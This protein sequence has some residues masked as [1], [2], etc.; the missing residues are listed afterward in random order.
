M[1]W[2][3]ANL[4]GQLVY[5]RATE[6]GDLAAVGGKVEIRY[7]PMD[8]R[9]YDAMVANLKVEPGPL[10]PDET[11]AAAERPEKAAKT[12]G[13]KAPAKAKKA[14]NAPA[15]PR[16]I[17][18]GTTIAYTDGACTGNPGPAGLGVVIVK[19]EGRREL[20][21]YLGEATNNIAELVA[22]ERAIE[23]TAPDDVVVHT[24]SQ[25]AIGVLSKGWKAKANTDLNMRIRALL[26]A[27]SGQRS[28]DFVYVPGHAG[29][30]LNERADEL[31]RL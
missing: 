31:A 20:S 25:Y 30:P 28:V 22:I 7:K 24:D 12:N 3:R 27:R 10:L 9:R 6:T 16:E 17:K 15:K 4:R 19:P 13:D 1:P 11:C 8:G 23:L 2:V 18:P 29:V 14:A 26:S 21:E 5:A